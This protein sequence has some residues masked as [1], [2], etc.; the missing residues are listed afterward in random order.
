LGRDFADQLSYHRGEKR[1]EAW[2]TQADAVYVAGCH[3]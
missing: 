3:N 1:L 2:V